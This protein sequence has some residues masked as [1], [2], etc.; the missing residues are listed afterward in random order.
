MDPRA[1]RDPRAPDRRAGGGADRPAPA[2]LRAG[3]RDGRRRPCDHRPAH[4]RDRDARHGVPVARRPD[5]RR[6]RHARRGRVRPLGRVHGLRLRGRAG[7][8]DARGRARASARSSSA[9]TCSRGSWTG[10]TARRSC[11]SATARARSSW[12]QVEQG[13][14]LGF[15][16]GADGGGGENLWLPGSGS[17]QF[18]DP[19]RFVK[20]NGRE[21]FKFA[22]RVMVS[23]RRGDPGRVRTHGRRRRRVRARTRRTSGSST[24]LLGNWGFP[25]RRSSSTSIA[26]ATRP[27][28]RF[29]S[30]SRTRPTTAASN[31]ASSC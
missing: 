21:V 9:A 5:R 25:R 12:R 13:G 31:R 2:G 30:H 1:H 28:A 24:T 15:E 14:F 17:R 4:R 8:R 20:M 6:A 18:E 16:L 3:A 11:C 10:P 27:Q 7:P 29:R 19:E 22:T 23:L 26:T